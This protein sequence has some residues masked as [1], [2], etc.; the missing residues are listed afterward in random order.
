MDFGTQLVQEVAASQPD[1]L[2]MGDAEIWAENGGRP[3]ENLARVPVER[4]K[5]SEGNWTK[6]VVERLDEVQMAAYK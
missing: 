3:R 6:W 1:P 5:D 4:C 2:I